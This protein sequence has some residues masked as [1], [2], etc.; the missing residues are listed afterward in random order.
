Q[1]LAA[2]PKLADDLRS[3]H[4]Y[5]AACA[6]ALAGC[7][8]GRGPALTDREKE[9]LR[10]QA[11]GWLHEERK[12]RA[13]QLKSLRPAEAARARQALA[14]WQK[15]RALAGVRDK[16][17]LARLPEAERAGWAKLWAEVDSLLAPAPRK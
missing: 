9:A 11:L 16:D 17:A 8:K 1:A 14:H 10:R 4:R 3:W 7:G 2:D 5:N 6:G 15:D 13:G 12:A